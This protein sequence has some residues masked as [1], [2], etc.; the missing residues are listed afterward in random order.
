MVCLTS[1]VLLLKLSTNFDSP[2]LLRC[3]DS[4]ADDDDDDDD[5]GP[6]EFGCASILLSTLNSCDTKVIGLG[7]RSPN[8]YLIRLPLFERVSFFITFSLPILIGTLV[9]SSNC[10][11]TSSSFNGTVRGE[12][13]NNDADGDDDDDDKSCFLFSEPD[14]KCYKSC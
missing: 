11:S 9:D 5:S 13:R 7:E 8:V 6:D 2:P 3:G 1:L 4:A 14:G 12:N 10:F